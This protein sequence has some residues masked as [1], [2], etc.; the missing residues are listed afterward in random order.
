[1][2]EALASPWIPLFILI[3][4][5]IFAR[6]AQKSWLAP[7]A[8]AGLIWSVYILVP[9]AVA[10]EFPVSSLSVW[11]ILALVSSIQ[12][13]ALLTEGRTGLPACREDKPSQSLVLERIL[14]VVLVSA[15]LA[16]FGVVYHAWR[17]MGQYGLPLSGA[18]LIA[19]GPLLSA[20]RYAGENEPLFVRLLL[21]WTFPAALLGGMAYV[22]ADSRRTKLMSLAAFAP[23]LLLAVAMAAKAQTLVAGCCWIAG[24]LA[25]KAYAT[26][27]TFRLFKKKTLAV[28]AAGVVVLICF[29]QLIGMIRAQSWDQEL[30]FGDSWIAIK[31]GTLGYLAVFNHWLTAGEHWDLSYGAYT[32]AGFFNMTGLH[33][34]QVGI[35]AT[36]VTL[37][38]GEETNIYTA[39][40]GVI[41]DFSLPGAILFF[42]LLGLFSGL[43][44]GRTC[45]GHWRAALGMAAFYGFL[46]WSQVGSLVTYNGPVL[47]WVV[48][49]LAL[50]AIPTLVPETP[51]TPAVIMRQV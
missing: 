33:A 38:G 22:L 18:G 6:C 14:R 32:F 19:L 23:A 43:A 21:M 42:F 15:L 24:F 2:I 44:Y 25:M 50:S 27:G 29:I 31:A 7:S 47:A 39:F 3:G 4:L 12:V 1:M 20:A 34:R 26:R 9:L 41:Q 36:S 37:P 17:S 5:A 35:Y 30:S 51:K 11:V 46:I 8:F 45:R 40:R 13:G 48:G 49:A 10:P 28:A 16:A